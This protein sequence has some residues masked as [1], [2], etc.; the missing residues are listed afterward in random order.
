MASIISASTTS[1]TALNLSGDTTGILQLST[2]AT[3]TTAV[4]IDA[5]QNVGIG[6]TSASN[7]L[8][9]AG[10]SDGG[11]Y[12]KWAAYFGSNAGGASV[13]NGLGLTLG[14]NYSAG[15][16]ESNIVYGT[17]AGVSPA[18]A[19]SSST[20]TVQTE[21]M[22]IDS[23]GNVGIGTNS[24]SSSLDVRGSTNTIITSQGTSGYGG[25]Y[26]RGSGTNAAYL[27][28]GNITNGEGFRLTNDAA[29][30]NASFSIG[31]SATNVMLM[32]V[33]QVSV[34]APTAKLGYG[35]GSGGTVTQATS[36]STAVTLNKPTGQITTA[37]DALASLASAT[38]TISNSLITGADTVIVTSGNV[39][40]SVRAITSS[41]GSFQII[42]KNESGGSLSQAVVINF[43]II[44]GAT[45]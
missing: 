25:F 7:T 4:T 33:S 8:F 24:P 11:I 38:F 20:G 17:I 16:G 18:L 1:A 30:G 44:K 10:K 34:V 40:Y 15:G 6:T 14:W 21:R 42:I 12:T 13:A 22:R 27:F 32:D 9:S 28:M 35:T 2:G 41:S 29:N 39:N 36:K 26:A 45:S 37:S 31:S 43:A 23:S 5:S 3:P 19:F